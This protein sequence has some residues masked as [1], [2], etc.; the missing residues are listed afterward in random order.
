MIRVAVLGGEPEPDIVALGLQ[1]LMTLAPERSLDFVA[2]YLHDRDP[3]IAQGA[4][5]A[6][7]ESRLPESFS[8]L[9]AVA[10]RPNGPPLTALALPMALTRD[11]QAFDYLLRAVVD[12]ATPCA[13]A[14][15]EAL[16]IYQGDHERVAQVGEAVE[17]RGGAPV[18]RAFR[19]HFEMP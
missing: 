5:L 2:G 16:A 3:V 8:V 13:V 18:A 14:A 11:E 7:G 9:R 17:R 12:E 15:V 4:A 6:I 10:G 19:Q 1:A